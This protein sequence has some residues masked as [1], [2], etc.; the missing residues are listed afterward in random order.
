MHLLLV[1]DDEM[2][3]E[4]VL[5][6][7]RRANYTVDWVHDGHAVELCLPDAAYDLVL[8]DLH[9]SGRDGLDIL[10]R[11]RK[12]GGDA[13]VMLV[14]ARDVSEAQFRALDAGGDDYWLKPFGSA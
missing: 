12:I 13:L 4:T 14:T 7:L 5:A 2:I 1:E 8:L 6:A 10:A 9:L 11:C 3:G